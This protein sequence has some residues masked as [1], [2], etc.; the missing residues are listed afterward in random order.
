[1]AFTAFQKNQKISNRKPH[2][3]EHVVFLFRA[4]SE[5]LFPDFHT[6]IIAGSEVPFSPHFVLVGMVRFELTQPEA[7]D[8][9]SAEA[10]QLPRIPLSQLKF[11]FR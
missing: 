1:M 8:L 7:A 5:S 9:Q 3:A 2:A 4:K 10:L 6:S 11:V